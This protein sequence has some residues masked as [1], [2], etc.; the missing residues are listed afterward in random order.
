MEEQKELLRKILH[1]SKQFRFNGSVLEL[2]HYY[3]GEKINLDL[4]V[5]LDNEE[6]LEQMIVEDEEEEF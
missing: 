3:T 2:T 5:L 6:I 1:G 4:E